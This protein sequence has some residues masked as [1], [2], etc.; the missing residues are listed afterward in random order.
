MSR[1]SK[2]FSE[3][4]SEVPVYDSI[5]PGYSEIKGA[6]TAPLGYKWISNNKS[7]FGGERKQA[8]VRIGARSEERYSHVMRQD[9]PKDFIDDE[10]DFIEALASCGKS[11]KKTTTTACR[12]PKSGGVKTMAQKQSYSAQ[13]KCDYYSKRVNNPKLS[14]KQRV[15]AQNRLNALCGGKSSVAGKAMATVP[16]RSTNSSKYNDAQKYAYGAGIGYAA[17]KSGKRVD[18]KPEN[19][20]SFRDGY[21]RGQRLKK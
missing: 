7:Y 19:K 8:L 11:S 20:Q 13:D 16:S 2:L 17:A 3:L 10:W 14:E 15:Y 5:P 1:K 9:Y 6:T 4:L 12:M 21:G 18:V